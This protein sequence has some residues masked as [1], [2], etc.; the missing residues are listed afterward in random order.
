M[1]EGRGSAARGEP[2]QEVFGGEG[3]AQQEALHFVAAECLEELALQ[4]RLD[5]LGDDAVAERAPHADDRGGDRG[6]VRIV[7]DVARTVRQETASA[8]PRARSLR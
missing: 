3:A 5:A 7:V 4:R 1:I 2:A 8:T 6:V